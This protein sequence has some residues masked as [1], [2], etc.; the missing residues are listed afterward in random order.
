LR[1]RENEG[2]CTLQSKIDQKQKGS[3]RWW[4]LVKAE[5]RR[6]TDLKN[7]MEDFLHKMSTRLVEEC[8]NRGCDTIV[9]G[10]LTGIRDDIDYGP[11]MNRRLHQ[12]AFRQFIEKVEYKADRYGVTIC[13][14]GEAHTS[15]TCPNCGAKVSPSDRRFRCSDCGFEAHRDQVGAVAIRSLFLDEEEDEDLERPS[16]SRVFEAL[17]ARASVSQ[18][19]KS[20]SSGRKPQLSLFNEG[21]GS[22]AALTR[23]TSRMRPPWILDYD[24]HMQCVFDP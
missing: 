22:A 2:R 9:F 16:R 8:W 24:P 20:S 3:S 18:E 17:R 6:R 23:A 1:H 21:T 5:K 14:I 12:W 11:D 13:E 10:D 7:K 15:S 19:T 4:K